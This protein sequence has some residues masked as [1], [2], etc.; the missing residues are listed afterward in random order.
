VAGPP[1]LLVH[2]FASSFE[3]NWRQPGWVDLLADLGRRV[4]EVDLLG[5]GGADKPH[6]PA[7]YLDLESGVEAVLPAEKVD[8]VGFS[9]GA[10]VLLTLA[11]SD[12]SR[13]GRVV[14]GGVGENLFRNDDPEPVARAIERS[15]AAEGDVVAGAFAR[16]ANS[17]DNDPRAL[18]ACLRRPVGPMDVEALSRVTL[19]VLVVLGDRDFAGPADPLVAALPEARLVTLKGVDHLATPEDFGFIDAALSFLDASDG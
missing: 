16:F 12:P 11:S 7:A 1:V 6:D 19:P 15:G 17:A 18:A 9:L 2:G 5:H 13:F 14:V 10:R 3:R 8:A 4:I